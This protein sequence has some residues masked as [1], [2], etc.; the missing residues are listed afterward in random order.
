MVLFSCWLD[1]FRFIMLF[2]KQTKHW[3]WLITLYFSVILLVILLYLYGFR[4]DI[5]SWQEL[6][7]PISTRHSIH[8]CT[9]FWV[10]GLNENGGKL[11]ILHN[12]CAFILRHLQLILAHFESHVNLNHVFANFN[13]FTKVIIK[14]SSKFLFIMSNKTFLPNNSFNWI[15]SFILM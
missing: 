10:L 3:H 1:T 6:L 8:I 5:S 7:W 4:M 14:I 13:K 15:L 9:L 12:V 11:R 2:Q